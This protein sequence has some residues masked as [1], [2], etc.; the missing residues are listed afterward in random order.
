MVEHWSTKEPGRSWTPKKGNQRT[1]KIWTIEDE[2][3]PEKQ[4]MTTSWPIDT[5][6]NAPAACCCAPRSFLDFNFKGDRAWHEWDVKWRTRWPVALSGLVLCALTAA[7]RCGTIKDGAQWRLAKGNGSDKLAKC[8]GMCLRLCV[9]GLLIL[10]I[11]SYLSDYLWQEQREPR[12]SK[13][14]V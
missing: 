14:C 10:L 6:E 5:K 2:E 1:T 12:S 9:V 4:E 13:I 3:C 8:C 7:V 11:V